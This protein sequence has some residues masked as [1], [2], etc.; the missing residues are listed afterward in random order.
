V[1]DLDRH[2]LR[3]VIDHVLR[4]PIRQAIVHIAIWEWQRVEQ[5]ASNLLIRWLGMRL[6]S[7][8]CR[9]PLASVVSG[10]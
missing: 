3:G 1:I 10:S 5:V 7:N 4:R 6:F 8:G 9:L 2:L